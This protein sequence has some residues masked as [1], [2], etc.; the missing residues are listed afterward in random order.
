[1]PRMTPPDFDP[2]RYPRTYTASPGWRAFWLLVG[3]GTAAGGLAMLVGDLL[4]RRPYGDPER[5]LSHGAG[6]LLMALLGLAMLAG[7]L[8]ARIVLG[9]DFIEAR[10][11][12]T[13]RLPRADIADYRVHVHNGM[14]EFRLRSNARRR[15]F[16][17]TQVFQADDAFAAWFS[18][19]V[20]S[21]ALLQGVELERVARDET[22]GATAQVRFERVDS[23]RRAVRWLLVPAYAIAFWTL[24]NPDPATLVLALT[25]SQP[26]VALFLAWRFPGMFTLARSPRPVRAD[27]GVLL[28]M[29][30]LAL[31]GRALQDAFLSQPW[32]LLAPALAGGAGLWALALAIN[33]DLRASRLQATGMALVLV[34]YAGGL[35]ALA[36]VGLDR[37]APART[38]ATVT[39]KRM[40]SG[41]GASARLTLAASPARPEAVERRVP[42]ALYRRVAVGDLVC[43]VDHP[44][45]F[46]WH[47]SSVEGRDT[48]AT[49]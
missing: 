40:T 16:T 38:V 15:P 26:F 35:L 48:C 41:K 10:T 30:G 18:G 33:D 43:V 13:W 5:A 2:A 7:V 42:R 8:R 45:A 44:G 17:F 22:L 24:V 14:R 23:A 47:W 49:R 27:L 39:A 34:L 29:P 6:W 25:V 36:D 4:L 3:G 19:L 20:D 12:G 37:A 21:D 28:L 11:F 32:S 1:M 9:P 31:A 46:G